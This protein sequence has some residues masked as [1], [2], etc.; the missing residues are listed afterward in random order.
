MGFEATTKSA[1]AWIF[2]ANVK[3]LS[4]RVARTWLQPCR[5]RVYTAAFK[6]FLNPKGQRSNNAWA[7]TTNGLFKAEVIHRREP[8]KS[9][10][11]NVT[12]EWVDWFNN[13][14]LLQPNGNIPP[15][16]AEQRCHDNVN[17]QPMASRLTNLCQ[18]QSRRRLLSR[19]H[20]R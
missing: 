10:E 20:N 15:A 2:V 4:R 18:S 16:K 6:R 12:L 7:E 1:V 8:W 14:S 11:V 3:S 5:V 9:F 17:A 19:H 13:G